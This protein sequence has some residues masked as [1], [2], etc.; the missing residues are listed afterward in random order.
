MKI[1]GPLP[2]GTQKSFLKLLLAAF[3]AITGLGLSSCSMSPISG[4]DLEPTE[5]SLNGDDTWRISFSNGV[6]ASISDEDG[7]GIKEHMDV[8]FPTDQGPHWLSLDVRVFEN[9]GSKSFIPATSLL[10]IEDFMTNGRS[11]YV[12]LS[13]NVY[14]AEVVKSSPDQNIL[15]DHSLPIPINMSGGAYTFDL[16]NLPVGSNAYLDKGTVDAITANNV[17]AVLSAGGYIAYPYSDVEGQYLSIANPASETIN[18]S[19]AS[20]IPGIQMVVSDKHGATLT[21]K[22]N[23]MGTRNGNI[24]LPLSECIDVI[25]LYNGTGSVTKLSNTAVNAFLPVNEKKKD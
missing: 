22:G 17:Y 6:K 11:V 18:F 16:S 1:G 4:L 5:P 21:T 3:A 13:D 8:E 9:D 25:Q 14:Q 23:H 2:D 7:D 20:A 19:L 10:K 12:T 24:S 15:R